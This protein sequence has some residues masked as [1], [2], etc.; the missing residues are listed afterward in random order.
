MTAAFMD[1]ALAAGYRAPGFANKQYNDNAEVHKV[2]RVLKKYS[3]L[4]RI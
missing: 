1:P 4:H 3:Y 2:L